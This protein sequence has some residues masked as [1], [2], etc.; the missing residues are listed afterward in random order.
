MFRVYRSWH[1]N[2]DTTNPG[3]EVYSDPFYMIYSEPNPGT[4][5]SGGPTASQMYSYPPATAIISADGG[6]TIPRGIIH[7]G[8]NPPH[9]AYTGNCEPNCDYP[10]YPASI[11]YYSYYNYIGIFKPDHPEAANRPTTVRRTTT[12]PRFTTTQFSNRYAFG[13][14]GSIKVTPGPNKFGGTMRYF[15]GF[16][17]R[18]YQF[19]TTGYP[20]C[21]KAYLHNWRTGVGPY[22]SPTGALDITEYSPQLVG[23]TYVGF[24]ATRVHTRSTEPATRTRFLTT[25]GDNQ[26]NTRKTVGLWTTMPWT[27]GRLEVFQSGGQYVS[28]AV[29]TGY[30]N[31]TENREMG[32]LSLVVP[33][34]THNYLTSFNPTDPIIAGFH[35]AAINKVMV[36]FVPEPAGMMLLGAGILGVVGVY[37]LR[38]R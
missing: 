30:D 10:G 18:G 31:R 12:S 25:A 26:Y 28:T 38:R 37:R 16:N 36:R 8:T 4:T 14:V 15:W 7:F 19:V 5:Q 24:G 29:Q 27:T 9:D 34:L 20:C 21:E 13:R 22:G 2:L 33:W 11:Y 35:S 17:A 32:T 1:G 3:G 23:G 6:F